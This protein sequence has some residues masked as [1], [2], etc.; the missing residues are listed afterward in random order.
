[1]KNGLNI[2]FLGGAKRVSLAERFLKVGQI[3]ETNIQVFSYE[4]YKKVP[5][6]S[7]GEVI[8]GKD[9]S[10]S[11]I[12]DDLNRIVIEK[13]ISIILACVDPATVILAR[14]NE[15]HLKNKFVSSSVDTCKIFLDK[16]IM[17][18]QCIIEGIRTIP[19][20]IN[21]YPMFIKPR[22]GSASKG[23]YV[24]N[25]SKD[26]EY[27]STRID[28]NI[29]IYQRYIDGIEYTV[30]AYVSKEGKFIG[31]VPRIRVNVTDGESTTAR[32]VFDSEIIH[33][34][35]LILS[36]FDLKGPLT[37]QFIRKGDDLYFL[38]LNPRFGGGVIASIEAGFNIPKIMIQDFMG[39]KIK[40]PKRIKKLIMTRCH[41][42]VFHAIDN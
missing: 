17:Y 22:K 39:K 36:K 30:D 27:I 12:Y 28:N 21:Q 33:Q 41:R 40:P 4:I 3:S 18:E 1:M 9:W 8:L 42:E 31:A 10:D 20:S 19:L 16:K 14:F 25:N 26:L 6:C 37:L 34:T 35:E 38:E 7:V 11:T 24:L 32:I 5:F 23:T 29:Y 15:M 2:L 13:N